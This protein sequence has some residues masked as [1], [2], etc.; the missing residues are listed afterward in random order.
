MGKM[1]GYTKLNEVP[2]MCW[3]G[4]CGMEV[5]PVDVDGS[6]EE[7]CGMCGKMV[8]EDFGDYVDSALMGVE[9]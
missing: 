3:C 2:Q 8:Y 6:G 1:G 7:R 4:E 9:V 5:E